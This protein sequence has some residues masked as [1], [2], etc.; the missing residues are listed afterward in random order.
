LRS[1]IWTDWLLGPLNDLY[2][3][4]WSQNGPFTDETQFLFPTQ[5]QMIDLSTV[6]LSESG[7]PPFSPLPGNSSPFPTA[8]LSPKSVAGELNEAL[9]NFGDE[10]KVLVKDPSINAA[11]LRCS[12][13]ECS[14]LTFSRR[15]DL[16]YVYLL[17][18]QKP[19]TDL[20]QQTQSSH[21]QPTTQVPGPRL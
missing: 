7:L 21:P 4:L 5:Q 14:S 11:I 6:S 20:S 2:S 9:D 12:Y 18:L 8:P 10:L 13:S 17:D 3:D 19:M 15:C 16:K 1:R